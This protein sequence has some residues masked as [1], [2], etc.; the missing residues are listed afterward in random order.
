MD[1]VEVRRR[2]AVI[3]ALSQ[4]SEGAHVAEDEL[5]IDVLEA[6]AD[7]AENPQG[8]AEEALRANDLDYL[9]WYG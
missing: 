7:G 1:V 9:R 8:L 3:N 6:I 2:V 4:D 5:Y